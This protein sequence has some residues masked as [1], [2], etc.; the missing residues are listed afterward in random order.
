MIY[1]RNISLDYFF[2]SSQNL[3]ANELVC[4]CKISQFIHWIHHSDFLYSETD[5]HLK[6]KYRLFLIKIKYFNNKDWIFW[7]DEYIISP[8]IINQNKTITFYNFYGFKIP[9]SCGMFQD[10]KISQYFPTLR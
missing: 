1:L 3:Y 7:L 10:L 9:N 5:Y 6:R 2:Q 4:N 8:G